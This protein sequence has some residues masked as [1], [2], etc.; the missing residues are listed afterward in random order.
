[1]DF[2]ETLRTSSSCNSIL[3]IVD[4]LSKQGIFI[5]T[6]IHCT[7][8]DLA[9]LFVMHVFSKHGILEHV[10][11]DSGPEF[12]S[13][14]FRSLGKAL[15]MKLHF[16]SGYHPKCDRQTKQTNQTLEQYLWIFCNYQ[17][18]NWYTLLPLVEFAYNNTPSAT[19]GISTFFTN[20]GYHPNFT[21]HPKQDLA[22]SCARDLV[23]N[24]DELLQELKSTISEAQLRYQG[25]T[26]AKR[27]LA[28]N[29]TVGEQ[30]FIKAKF[31]HTTR[32]S[33]K[34]SNKFLGPFEILAKARTHSFTLQ[35]PDIFQGVHPVFLVSMLEPAFPNE[36]P[37]RVQ[38]LPPLVDIE[39][40]LEYE[41]SKIVDSKIDKHQSCKLLYLVCWLGYENTDEELSWLPTMEL[42]HADEL[43]SNF[44]STYPQKP[45]PISKL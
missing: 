28:L 29:F 41:I 33:H 26:N 8:K 2:I 9:M 35:L 25:P 30:A 20:K 23:V 1:M 40:K 5:L 44:H 36:I 16:T 24:L 34:L 45:G 17:Q 6:T 31:F 43:V 11:S 10:T 27:S 21:I 22:L 12:V 3:V 19:T 15:D 7:S 32:P 18:D 4:Q 38:S 37:N 39:G 14:F 42:E 13:C